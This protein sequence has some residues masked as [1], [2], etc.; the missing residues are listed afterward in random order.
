MNKL[1]LTITIVALAGAGLWLNAT[2]TDA[3]LQP[4]PAGHT[5]DT[6]SVTA[7]T[8]SPVVPESITLWG[9]PISLDRLDMWERLDRELSAMTYT[10][11]TTMLM[12]KRA[13]RYFPVIAP[14]LEKNG[15]PADMLYLAS[16]ESSMN[17][18]ALS[19]AKAAGLWQFMPAT[20]KEYGLEVNEWVD[21]RYNIEKATEAACRFLKNA[22]SK[23]GDW[24][25]VAVSYNA[26]MGRISG[27]KKAQ[28]Q[29]DP[30]DL[31]LVEETSRY[32]FRIMAAKLIMEDPQAYG[33]R[34]RADQLYQPVKYNT[35]EV[36]GPVTDWA[37]WAVEH[38]TTY[39]Q[40][41][42]ANPWIRSKS[43]PNKTGKLYYVKIP[44]QDK[45]YRSKQ[46]PETFNKKWIESNTKTGSAFPR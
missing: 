7:I 26:G 38:G 4:E 29:E 45:F 28:Q 46:K 13:N 18:K 16:I 11:G 32:L 2:Q 6:Q 30:F 27:E 31:Y 23:Y 37:T 9:E 8:Q 35:V 43:L 12:L 39:A 42:E 41:R 20:G 15:V 14:I 40:V 44:E 34:F 3:A 19:P 22:Y 33:F 25:S 10:H 5:A 1:I 17:P 24:N 21:E 36:N